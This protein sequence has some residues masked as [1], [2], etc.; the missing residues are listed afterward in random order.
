MLPFPLPHL[1]QIP[2]IDS[3]SFLICPIAVLSQHRAPCSLFYQSW[4]LK[5]NQF[6]VPTGCQNHQCTLPRY[7]KFWKQRKSLYENGCLCNT[8]ILLSE[9]L[10]QFWGEHNHRKQG[11]KP[12]DHKTRIC[13]F[14][15]KHSFFGFFF[16]GRNKTIRFK[17]I[18]VSDKQVSHWFMSLFSRQ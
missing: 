6:A 13:S 3:G 7:V 18:R 2:L 14:N 15:Y 11:E 5:W 16:S 1:R 10:A 4:L 8:K 9:I 12:W 17:A